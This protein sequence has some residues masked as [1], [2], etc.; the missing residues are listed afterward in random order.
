MVPSLLH[1]M[2]KQWKNI[3]EKIPPPY[4]P[5]LKPAVGLLCLL[6]VGSLFFALRPSPSHWAVLLDGEVMA[7]G[8]SAGVG[9]RKADPEKKENTGSKWKH[10]NTDFQQVSGRD[11]Q[12]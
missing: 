11:V 8:G 7:G 2:E 4:R 12:L 3:E 5:F 9:S 1:K 6:L 10:C